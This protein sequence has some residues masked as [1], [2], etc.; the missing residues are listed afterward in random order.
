MRKSKTLIHF[1]DPGHGWVRVRR[2]D[3]I[4]QVIANEVTSCSYQRGNYVYL[5]EDYD[6]GLYYKE[7][8]A[9]GYE[10]KWKSSHTDKMS[11]IRSYVPYV[12]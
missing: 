11:K 6:L 9:R 2:D 1:T 4:F 12:K 7:L 10:I 3:L 5:E 8:K